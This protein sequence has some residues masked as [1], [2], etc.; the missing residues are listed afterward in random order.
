MLM[1]V[2]A[3]SRIRNTTFS[4]NRVGQVLALK[5]ITFGATQVELD[6][7]VLRNTLLGNI[8]S[9]HDL[10]SGR[11]STGHLYRWSGHVLENAIHSIPDPVTTLIRFKVNI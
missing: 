11:D 3:E 9:G 6:T 10:Q 1:R 5:S 4:P 7:A 2:A 8:Q